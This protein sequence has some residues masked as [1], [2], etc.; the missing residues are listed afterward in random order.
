MRDIALGWVLSL[1]GGLGAA[2]LTRHFLWKV[3]AIDPEDKNVLQPITTGLIER[4]LFTSLIQFAS[5]IILPSIV[6]SMIGWLALKLAANWNHGTRSRSAED[7]A[8][9]K[10]IRNRA[11]IAVIVGAMSMAFA[12]AGGLLCRS[13]G[14]TILAAVEP[15]ASPSHSGNT[16]LSWAAASAVASALAAIASLGAVLRLLYLDHWK[17]SKLD[18]TFKNDRDVTVQANTEGVDPPIPPDRLSKWLRINVQAVRGRLSAKNCRA[19]LISA[20]TPAGEDLFPIYTR[21]LGWTHDLSNTPSGR[22]LL[23]GINHWVDVA[24]AVEGENIL[25]LC[26]QPKYA[27]PSVGEF[28]VS[29]QVSS[30]DSDPVQKTI[31]IHW[32][33][34][35]DSLSGRDASE[36]EPAR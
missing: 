13:D 17:R 5:P 10:L 1:V 4:A 34:T 32:D 20:K 25:R 26:V 23:P 15:V 33:G 28:H 24:Y 14:A 29:V 9:H 36:R 16:S 3:Y 35:W 6:P 8:A 22:E 2:E 7:E 11:L 19:Y 12:Y 30:A 21:E 27:I 18:C 31:V